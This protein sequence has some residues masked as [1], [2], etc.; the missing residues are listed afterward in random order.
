MDQCLVQ[1]NISKMGRGIGKENENKTAALVGS[2]DF[3]RAQTNFFLYFSC[4]S[5]SEYFGGLS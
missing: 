1:F 2:W 3:L 4:A 5:D